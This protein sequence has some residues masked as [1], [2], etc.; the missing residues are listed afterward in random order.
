MEGIRDAG[1]EPERVT[2]CGGWDGGRGTRLS[3]QG[4]IVTLYRGDA[5]KHYLHVRPRVFT[6]L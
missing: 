5:D 6:L 1:S 2:D 3:K 4:T